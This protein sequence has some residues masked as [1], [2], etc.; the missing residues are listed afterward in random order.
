MFARTAMTRM[1]YLPMSQATIDIV[2]ATAPV[3]APKAQAITGTFYK[4]MFQNNP[5]ALVFFNKTNQLKGAQ[6][7][8][9][10]D[11]V[12]AYALNIENLGVLGPAVAKMSH[13]HC[14]LGVTPELYQIVHDNLMKA[15]GEELGDAV[16]P[17]IGTGWSNAVMALAEILIGTE[18]KLYTSAEARQGGWRGFKD[19]T[20]AKKT[21]IADDTMEFD[22][23]S[24]DGS[25]NFEFDAGQY[26]SIR[27]PEDSGVAAPRHYTVTS[28]PGNETLQCTTR[29]VRG[30]DGNPDGAVSTYMHQTLKEGD[31]VR[32]SAPFGVFTQELTFGSNPVAFV[33]A[34]IGITPAWAFVQGGAK[35]VAGALHVESSGARDAMTSKLEGA[36]VSNLQKLAGKSRDE[37]IEA[38]GKFANEVGTGTHFVTCGPRDFMKGVD[39]AL[40]QAGAQNIHY[41]IFGTGNLK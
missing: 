9:L 1:S 21:Q 30:G 20:L 8:A 32:L 22:F 36:G 19:F 18:E 3:V 24:A 28:P 33:T 12:V 2:K 6:S 37:V 10:A 39:G 7:G 34:G 5:E 35:N 29:R 14:A 4:T 13:R 25:K 27:L 38:V 26:L 40:R 41:E 16:T 11:A 31:T 15:I 23:A 17:E